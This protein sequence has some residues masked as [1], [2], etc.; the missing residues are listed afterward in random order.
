VVAAWLRLEQAA[1]ES[2]AP[3]APHQTP[4]EFT[5]ALLAEHV[6]DHG[7]VD[8]LRGLYQQARFAR[9]GAISETDA[10]DAR[11]ALGA[12]LDGWRVSA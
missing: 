12:I 8:R 6:A 7:A 4:T 3:R 9:S 11:A 10:D 5:S 2:G 1:A